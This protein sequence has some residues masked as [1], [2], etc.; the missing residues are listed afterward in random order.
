MQTTAYR[1]QQ[2]WLEEGIYAIFSLLRTSEYI[3]GRTF[4][5]GYIRSIP[6]SK[7]PPLADAKFDKL[8]TSSS[9]KDELA[10]QFL[11]SIG[12]I[13]DDLQEPSEDNSPSAENSGPPAA[14]VVQEEEAARL[15][16]DMVRRE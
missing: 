7:L 2:T 9:E 8:M 3:K 6:K 14:D 15:H 10:F 11:S 4:E 13:L 16:Q 5:R 12:Q 1:C